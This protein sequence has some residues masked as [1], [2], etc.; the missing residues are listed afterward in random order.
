MPNEELWR[1]YEHGARLEQELVRNRWTYF[2]AMLSVSF[3]VGGL[4]LA[5]HE[6]LGPVLGRAGFAFG[7]LIYMA[8]FYHYWWFHKKAH[9]IRA[10]LCELEQQLGIN[11]Y[12]IRTRRP[13]LGSRPLYY[14][15]SIDT[16]AVAYTAMLILVLVRS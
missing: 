10:H 8:G 4:T 15:W 6:V 12:R 3:V 11:V 5:Q 16:L 9:D 7:W 2:T 13:R 1:E 14:H